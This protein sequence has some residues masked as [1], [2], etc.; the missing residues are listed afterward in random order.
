VHSRHCRRL[1]PSP[2]PAPAGRRASPGSWGRSSSTG[3][4]PGSWGQSSSTG[5]AR[6]LGS[7]LLDGGVARL[8]GSVLLDGGVARLAGHHVLALLQRVV[9]VRQHGREGGWRRGWEG[10]WEGGRV[11]GSEGEHP[12]GN[13]ADEA[14]VLDEGP[15]RLV[16][17][18]RCG[19]ESWFRSA[20]SSS[21]GGRR[22]LTMMLHI[23][24]TAGWF[25]MPVSR[26]P[27]CDGDYV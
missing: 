18:K 16:E 25:R 20:T 17:L 12:Q 11:G 26:D 22:L 10:G 9:H 13:E 1:E 8:L 14:E 27:R 5:V 23:I 19:L 7:F 15:K 4:S 24:L 21:C 3:A 2:P 6:L